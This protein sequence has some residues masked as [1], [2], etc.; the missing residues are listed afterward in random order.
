MDKDELDTWTCPVCGIRYSW[1]AS[2][3]PITECPFE[4]V[5]EEIRE[6]TKEIYREEP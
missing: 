3:D 5:C 6:R 2:S 1:T 4:G